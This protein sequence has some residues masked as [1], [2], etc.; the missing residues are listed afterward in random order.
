MRVLGLIL[1][2]AG[3]KGLPGKN[4]L[5]LA[6]VPMIAHT[7]RHALDAA[8]VDVVAVSTDDPVAAEVARAAGALLVD[9]PAELAD[10]GAAIVDAARHAAAAVES[11]DGQSRFDAVVILYGNVPIRPDGL[12]DD[13]IDKL[14]SSGC[15][16][17][18]SVCRT[19]KAHPYWMKRLLDG[20]R[21]EPY[22]PNDVHR[23]QDLPP[24]YLLDGGLIVVKR[25]QLDAGSD[26]P[27]GFLGADR[28]AV[29]TAAGAV[30]DVDG[31]VDYALARGLLEAPPEAGSTSG[32]DTAPLAFYTD[33]SG[34]AVCPYVIAEIGVNHDGSVERALELVRAARDADADAVKLQLFDPDLLMSAEAELAAYQQGA[35]SDP[36][37]MLR[38]LMLDEAAMARVRDLAHELDLDFVLTCFSLEQAPVM[39]RLAP[40]VVKIASPDCVNLPLIE[41]M[42]ALDRPMIMSL[43]TVTEADRDVVDRAIALGAAGESLALLHCVSAYPVPE[44]R[45]G[46]G[47]IPWWKSRYGLPVGYSDHTMAEDTGAWAVMA[48]AAVLEKHLTHD[49]AAPGPDHAASFAPDRFARYIAAARRAAGELY[50]AADDPEADPEADVRR[51]SRQSVCAVRDLPVG[52]ALSRDD[53]TLKRP[54]T[55]I[56]AARL[57]DV[58]GKTL[59]RA[60][61]ARHLLHEEDVAW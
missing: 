61:P 29:V 4:V 39:E 28:R 38:A 41:A 37:A 2:R 42:R 23:R 58:L 3:S 13:A 25:E 24:V 30:V 20:D 40:D 22:E 54:G 47:W 1:A 45:S 10:D 26:G 32:P 55:G 49:E 11:R 21:L 14:E 44:G 33:R 6:G 52:H 51:V 57:H 9:R 43:G 35:A 17:V 53:L 7:V 60:V 31:P 56:P 46:L 27:H 59:N 48:G 12:I 18:Q 50:G 5:P 16:S 8:R 15:H 36:H 19:G 34:G